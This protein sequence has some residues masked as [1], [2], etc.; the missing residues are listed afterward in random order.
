MKSLTQEELQRKCSHVRGQYSPFIVALK[1]LE[2]QSECDPDTKVFKAF[3]L[4][5][6]KYR[7]GIKYNISIFIS[8]QKMTIIKVLAL[9]MSELTWGLTED[10]AIRA[11]NSSQPSTGTT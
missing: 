9:P 2:D 7:K 11:T 5:Y 8:P 6:L 10:E 1:G 3:L 4:H